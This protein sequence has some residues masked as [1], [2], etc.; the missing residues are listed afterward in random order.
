MATGAGVEETERQRDRETESAR[1]AERQRTQEV[2]VEQYS[3]LHS[4]EG[5]RTFKKDHL[6]RDYRILDT[7]QIQ[8][9]PLEER[10]LYTRHTTHTPVHFVFNRQ[11]LCSF[12]RERGLF[13]RYL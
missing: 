11:A 5:K 12:G 3:A 4:R 8:E 6:K 1:G 10:V 7:L 2:Q 9:R 13:R